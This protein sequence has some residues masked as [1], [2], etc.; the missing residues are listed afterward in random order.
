MKTNRELRQIAV[1]ALK[2]EYGFSPKQSE[3][4]LQEARDDGTYILFRVA[5]STYRFDSSIVDEYGA[6]WAGKG[7]I[8]KIA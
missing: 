1:A 5:N 3:I 2:V 8:T 7:T 6:V 4:V